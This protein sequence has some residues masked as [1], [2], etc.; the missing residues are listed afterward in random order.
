MNGQIHTSLLKREAK[1]F[2]I[3]LWEVQAERIK[4]YCSLSAV[5]FYNNILLKSNLLRGDADS[6]LR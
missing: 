2:S 4:S 3:K 6:Q 1:R 5:V